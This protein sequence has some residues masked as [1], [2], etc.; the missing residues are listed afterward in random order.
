HNIQVGLNKT[1][2]YIRTNNGIEFSNQVLT[3]YYESVGTFHQKS[4]PR[5]PRQNSI[6]E[7]WNRTLV[8]AAR[9]MLPPISHQGVAVGPT[10]E[11]NP[12]SQADNDPFI[13]VFAPEPSFDE[14]SSR[15]VSSTESTQVVHLHNH[16]GKWS[17]EHPLDNVIEAIRIFIANAAIKNMII[18]QIYVK[19]AFL[20]GELKEEVCD[21]Q[22]EG[23][24]NPDHPTH[25][26]HLKKALYGL[27]QAPRAWYNTLS[28]FLLDNKFSK[29]VVDPTLFTQKQANIS[30]LFKSM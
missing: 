16:L 22:S 18:N 5:T 28:R 1:I 3:E 7:R 20:N 6:V 10:L 25:I 23:F 19:S 17:K 15:D 27:K 4:V 11:D 29:G 30:F 14:S 24:I 2:R 13:K 21:S 9:T 12:F 26:Y 8:E